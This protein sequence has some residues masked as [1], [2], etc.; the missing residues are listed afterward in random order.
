MRVFE[1]IVLYVQQQYKTQFSGRAKRSISQLRILTITYMLSGNRS[2]L[3]MMSFTINEQVGVT[4]SRTGRFTCTHRGSTPESF[5]GGSNTLTTRLFFAL[6]R[7]LP[8]SHK[9]V[10]SELLSVGSNSIRF[11]KGQCRSKVALCV[12]AL[13][14]VQY[15]DDFSG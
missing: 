9:N 6:F 8:A 11:L 5:G 4:A 7:T 2:L 14:N 3:S 15:L 1:W 12:N 13:T 10:V